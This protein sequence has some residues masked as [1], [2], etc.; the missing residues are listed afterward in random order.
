MRRHFTGSIGIVSLFVLATSGIAFAGSSVIIPGGECSR[1]DQ[2]GVTQ[3]E[4]FNGTSLYNSAGTSYYAYCPIA[5]ETSWTHDSSQ[6]YDIIAEASYSVYNGNCWVT[7]GTLPD[8]AGL[9]AVS[10][11]AKNYSHKNF[12]QSTDMSSYQFGYPSASYPVWVFEC[13]L[14]TVGAQ[15]H[16]IVI[17][18]A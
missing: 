6:S 15:L 1:I 5:H 14:P 18:H 8:W 4:Q 17:N 13:S 10:W 11:T 12:N 2:N 7:T 3:A 9:S 16:N